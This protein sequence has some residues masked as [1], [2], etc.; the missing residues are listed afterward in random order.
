MF[1]QSA[2]AWQQVAESGF[3]SEAL[4]WF[5]L[6]IGKGRWAASLPADADQ[7]ETE[8]AIKALLAETYP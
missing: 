1:W 4:S 6:A 7:A 8:A 5:N 3:C 2:L